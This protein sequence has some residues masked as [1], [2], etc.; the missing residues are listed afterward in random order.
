MGLAVGS[1]GDQGLPERALGPGASAGIRFLYWPGSS[2]SIEVSP[3]ALGPARVHAALAG[4]GQQTDILSF[5]LTYMYTSYETPLSH[6]FWQ[7]SATLF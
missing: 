5:S 7:P 3:L 1:T 4:A 2:F 6:V